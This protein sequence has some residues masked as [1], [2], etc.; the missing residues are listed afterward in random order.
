M[1]YQ[2]KK[3]LYKLTFKDPVYEGFEVTVTS[4]P[5]ETMLWVQGLGDR[6]SDIAKT[7]DGFRQMVDVLVGAILS[8]NLE[9]DDGRPIPV[10]A[11]ALL[12]EDPA[13]VKDVIVAWTAAI[14]GVS[15]PLGRRIDLW[16]AVP[17]GVDSDGNV[18]TE[19]AE[20]RRARFILG[21]L[22]TYPGYTLA[23][24]YAEDAELMQLL[25]IEERGRVED[26]P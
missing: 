22:R 20:L 18:V 15:G 11:G 19:P 25:A 23:S 10:S 14:T 9:D 26:A 4:V 2:A 3:K 1:G 5:M 13:F 16:T 12:A 7:P 24:L 6:V 8:W 17:G 21:V